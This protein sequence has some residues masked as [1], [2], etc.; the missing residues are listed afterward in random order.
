[1][2]ASSA[3]VDEAFVIQKYTYPKNKNLLYDLKGM[4]YWYM[5]I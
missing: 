3:I 5:I 2:R 1:M 4:L